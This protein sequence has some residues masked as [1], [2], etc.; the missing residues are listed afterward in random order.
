MLVSVVAVVNLESPHCPCLVS[1]LACTKRETRRDG[2]E[3]TGSL[4][5]EESELDSEDVC[6]L[7]VCYE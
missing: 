5:E 6:H 7:D 1:E 3:S 4:E 2:V